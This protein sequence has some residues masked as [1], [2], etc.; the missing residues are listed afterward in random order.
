MSL[1]GGFVGGGLTNLGTNYKM[2]NG[3]N[4]MTSEQAIQEVVYMARNGGLQDFLR[5][6]D[7]MQLGDVNLSATQYEVE[8]DNIVFAPGT[9]ENNQDLY[10]K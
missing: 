9:K 3:F 2:V 8:G 7:K 1:I 5:Q 10:I 4:N 6:V